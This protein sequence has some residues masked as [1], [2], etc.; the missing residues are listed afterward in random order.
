MVRTT[1]PALLLPR[2]CNAQSFLDSAFN[3][4]TYVIRSVMV[5]RCGLLMCTTVPAGGQAAG[6][7]STA[8]EEVKTGS[9]G[10]RAPQ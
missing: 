10:A 2:L 3:L 8:G 5:K 7:D 9:F 4:H 6:A 1:S